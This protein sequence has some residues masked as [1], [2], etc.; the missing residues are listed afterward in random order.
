MS[1]LAEALETCVMLDRTSQ[2]DGY[3]GVITTYTEGAE[4]QAAIT[5]DTSIQARTAEAA[6]AQNL[7][8]ITTGREVTLNY[9][10]LLKRLRDGKVFRVTSDGADKATPQSAGLN[11]RVVT[12]E[13]YV[14]SGNG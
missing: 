5:Y 11:M 14:V 1:L 4:I 2:S 6:G 9:H 8:T 10:D 12:A 13:E 3:G 7:F